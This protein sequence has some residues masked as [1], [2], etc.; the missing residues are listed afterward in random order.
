MKK[1]CPCIGIGGYW[2]LAGALGVAAAVTPAATAQCDNPDPTPACDGQIGIQGNFEQGCDGLGGSDNPDTPEAGDGWTGLAFPFQT[3]GAMVDAVTFTLNTNRAGGDIWIVGNTPDPN[4]PPTC[5]QPDITNVLAVICCGLEGLA[6]DVVHTVNF[7]AVA[8]SAA[9]PTWVVLVGR[10][11]LAGLNDLDGD[12]TADLPSFN[13]RAF[14]SHQVARDCNLDMQDPPQCQTPSTPNQAFL[15]VSDAAVGAP[16]E[17]TDLHDREPTPLGTPYCIDLVMLG[18]AVDGTDCVNNPPATGV[19]CIETPE[20]IIE[21]G[22]KCAIQGGIYGGDGT[23]CLFNPFGDCSCGPAAGGCV[24]P[25]DD[26]IPNGNGT[27]G[28]ELLRCC[29]VVCVND[30][31]CC[32]FEWDLNC[33]QFAAGVNACTLCQPPGNCQIADQGGHGS[34]L[35][36]VIVSDLNFPH[37]VADNFVPAANATITQVCWW[38]VYAILGGANAGDCSATFA[39]PDDFTVTY[40]LN[41]PDLGTPGFPGAVHAGPFV[42]DPVVDLTK[43]E[44]GNTLPAAVGPLIEFAYT[45]E[46][47]AVAVNAGQCYW[48]EIKNDTVLGSCVWLWEAGPPGDD[49]SAD[50]PTYSSLGNHPYDLAT[51]FGV[52]LG[53]LAACVDALPAA[54]TPEAGVCGQA[55]GSPG[56]D[57]PECCNLTCDLMPSCC[58]VE[59][60]QACADLAA[61]NCEAAPCGAIDISC[62]TITEP[63]ACG[64]VV[65]D[66]CLMAM[67]GFT[68][69][70]SGDIVNGTAW[71]DGG[72]RDTDWY[73][74]VIDPAADVNGDGLVQICLTVVSEMP[75]VTRVLFDAALDCSNPVGVGTHAYSQTC[76]PF[77]SGGSGDI[78]VGTYYVF[79]FIGTAAGFPVFDGYP[80]A[81]PNFGSNYMMSVD[82]IDNDGSACPTDRPLCVTACPWDCQATPS[83]AVD[84]PDLLAL[85]GAW[86]GPQTPGTTCDLDGSGAIAVP[87]LLKLLANW[88]SCP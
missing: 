22:Y 28:C 68:D 88:G 53:D 46:H 75:I 30:P 65:N 55:N 39:G 11:G 41:E 16:G 9:E 17:W 50:G 60:D 57:T 23:V 15:N 38:G 77:F 80:C 79:A 76:A 84:V 43:L 13:G 31:A 71:A 73:K 66:G 54:C 86:G 37:A 56:C 3:L 52:D 7:G 2:A 12:G 72:G 18:N 48:V 69:I 6:E 21:V 87:D 74:I 4:M 85:L 35:T 59:W 26:G 34:M 5:G 32:S 67:P 58:S 82:V 61:L 20:C 70:V 49:F 44:T 24:D 8:T 33:A 10:T 29:E 14:P 36:A 62:A 51:C 19:C 81:G 45:A 47:P 63:E 78:A 25:D 27:P 83:G 1:V 40:F 42:I 64:T